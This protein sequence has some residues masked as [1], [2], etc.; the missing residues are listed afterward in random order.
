[1]ALREPAAARDC[2]AGNCVVGAL[3]AQMQRLASSAPAAERFEALKF[4]VHFVGDVHQP[5]HVGFADDRG[6]NT[7]QLQAFG[8]GT[9][10]HARW[11]SAL[12]RDVDPNAQSLAAKLL[13]RGTLPASEVA[14]APARWAT[15]SCQIVSQPGFYPDRVLSD[16]YLRTYE[17][18]VEQ[19]L[20]LAGLRLAATLNQALSPSAAR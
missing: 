16:A 4:V 14:P 17:P 11:D 6:G 12:I 5:L 7:Y 20:Y 15:E 2:P 10:L 18:I 1:V 3:E 8:K 13:A 9:N 19:R